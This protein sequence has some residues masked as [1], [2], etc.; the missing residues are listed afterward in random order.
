MGAELAEPRVDLPQL[1]RH[2][3]RRGARAL[4]RFR[5]LLEIGDAGRLGHC[6]R[7]V[8][9]AVSFARLSWRGIFDCDLDWH[10]D[11]SSQDLDW[12]GRGRQD[13][14]M[15]FDGHV[16]VVGA[17]ERRRRVGPDRGDGGTG[18]EHWTA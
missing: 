17:G 6:W 14:S 10:V 8:G 12:R 18:P 15:H 9:P 16:I 7:R 1:V 4:T 5:G 3:G 2:M 13:G 11:F